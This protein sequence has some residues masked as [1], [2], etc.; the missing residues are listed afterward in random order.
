MLKGKSMIRIKDHKQGHLFD[1]WSFLSPKRRQL[2]NQ[3]WAALFK[4]QILCELPVGKLAPFFHDS[5]GRPTKE[6]HTV[7]A[8]LVLQQSLDLDDQETINQL[9]F[10]TQ[11]HYA[12]N[13]AEE[14]DSA[15][16]MCPKTLWNMRSIAVENRLEALLFDRITNKLADVFKVNTD[17]QRID[18]VHIKSN[19]R[20]LGRIGIFAKSIHKFLV[21]L[22]RGQSQQFEAVDKAIIDKYFSQQALGCFSMV[23]PSESKKT[24]ASVADDLFGLVEQ[25]KDREPVSAMHS[26]K[27]LERVLKEQCNLKV[28]DDNKKVEVKKPKEIASDSLQNPSD[29]D[30]AYSGHKGQG[31]QLQVMETYTD[32]EDKEVKSKTLNLITHVELEKACESDAQ[33]LI[34]AIESTQK[35]GLGPHELEADSLYGSDENYQAAKSMGVELVAPVKNGKP[36]KSAVSLSEFEFSK[37][38]HVLS[39][40]QGQKPLTSKKK[41]TRFTQGFG[42]GLCAKC[43]LLNDCPVKP[44][45]NYYYLRYEEKAMR[46]A[47]RRATEQTA[48]FKQ[49]YR[50]RAGSEATMS[51]LDRRT[52]VKRLRVRGFKAVRFS[53]TLKAIGINLFRAAAVR[54]AANHDN[55]DN[56]RIKSALNHAIFVVKEHL[57]R[58]F[59]PLSNYFQLHPTYI[60]H[61]LI[62]IS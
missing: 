13:I 12:L 43:P 16:Y 45:K 32:T 40:P 54:K 36:E 21:N 49:R 60:E 3:S 46:L 52:G 59:S 57:E 50:W 39:C 35:R 61:K 34:P 19:M 22:K 47:K 28:S 26:Y 55:A 48:E 41:K 27:L 17:K 38:G 24:L 7:L 2:L 29:P 53:A 20:R 5:F 58:I 42:C 11:W 37:T 56:S 33:A 51:E 6:L 62:T 18:S 44:G 8:V 23:K 9:A 4:D 14:S 10:N 31:Y 1:P 15:K 30:A 25:F